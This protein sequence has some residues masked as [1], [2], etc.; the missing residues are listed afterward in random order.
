VLDDYR[1]SRFLMLAVD[2]WRYGPR[3]DRQQVEL[4][5]FLD[6][7]LRTAARRSGLDDSTWQI[8]NA[9]D[10]RLA[11]LPDGGSEP[12]L[13]D[14]FVREL[15]TWL[16]R[17]NHE[18][19]PGARLRLRVAV[20]NGPAIPAPM[21]YGGQAVVHVCRLRDAHPVRAALDAA[22][23]ANLVLAVSSLVFDD[24]IRQRH[25][26]LSAADFTKFDVVDTAKDFT[27]S[28]WLRVPGAPATRDDVLA[29][30]LCFLV[31]PHDLPEFVDRVLVSAFVSA[32]IEV[33][34]G[35]AFG[36]DTPVIVLTGASPQAVLGLWVEHV[37]RLARAYA[38]GVRFVVGVC[39]TA[40]HAR[41]LAS[42]DAAARVLTG[43][44]GGRMAIVI[45]SH[46][47]ETIST[48]QGRLVRP[49]AYGRLGASSW[50]RVPG[51]ATPPRQADREPARPGGAGPSPGSVNTYG[52]HSPAFGTATI[53]T[54][55]VGEVHHHDG[56]DR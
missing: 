52:D 48:N 14:P 16:A 49:E 39:G 46:L 44:R 37:D 9:G 13:V 36:G 21:G 6:E 31:P 27:A 53:D 47:H 38:P 8:Q 54:F 2:A 55:V 20:H 12:V 23:N 32:G 35:T 5:H 30:G 50:L 40:D 1:F 25:T 45:P 26:S 3:D 34:A 42:S 41:E 19:V 24:V 17:H 22:P 29:V 4:Q 43:A 18:R 51:H 11:L 15:D 28:A 33:P 7:G 10:G 56:V